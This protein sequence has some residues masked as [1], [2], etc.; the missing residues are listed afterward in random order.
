MLRQ[1]LYT[2]RQA[3]E[4][5]AA[6]ALYW[7]RLKVPLPAGDQRYLL[8]HFLPVLSYHVSSRRWKRVRPLLPLSWSALPVPAYCRD[9]AQTAFAPLEPMTW[10]LENLCERRAS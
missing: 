2:W 3:L 10:L 4:C 5:V 9:L 1:R 8:S 7:Q 6:G